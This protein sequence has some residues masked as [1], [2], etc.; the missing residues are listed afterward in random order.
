MA[1]LGGVGSV[2]GAFTGATVIKLLDEIQVCCRASSGTATSSCRSSAS[3]VVLLLAYAPR[4]LWTWTLAAQVLAAS[5][6]A[7][8]EGRRPLPQ[9]DKPQQGQTL[10]EVDKVRKGLGAWWPSTT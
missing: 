3:I 2:W 5:A 4:G 8:G 1:V 6:S 10:L 7:T 9:R